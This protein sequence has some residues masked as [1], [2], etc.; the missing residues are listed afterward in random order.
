MELIYPFVLI[1][2]ILLLIILI[3]VNLKKPIAYESGKKVANTQYVKEIPYYQ[4]V[5]KKY[6]KL[7]YTIKTLCVISTVMSLVLI[8]RPASIDASENPQY[9]RDIILCM[10]VSDSVNELNEELV[11]NLKKVVK[12]LKGERFG[13]SIFNTS[14]VLLVPLTDD[15]DYV[16]ETLDN[17]QKNFA[18]RN[19]FL[20]T[21][22]I[23]GTDNIYYATE[24]IQAGTL[25][26]NEIRGSSIIGDGL[27]TAITNFG[28]LSEERTRIIIFSTDNEL[29]GK[30]LITLEEAGEMCKDRGITVFGIAP[31]TILG[32]DKIVMKNAVE[33][34]G[35][36]Y[37]TEGES[38]VANI[39]KNIEQKGKSLIKGK[40]ETKM[41]D[42]P[43]I[44]FVVLI[45]SVAGLFVLN[46]KVNL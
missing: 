23:S 34:T 2:G 36:T 38:N 24:Y 13:I 7:N 17:L 29:Y 12:S 16:I 32:S 1:I 3:F 31:S 41:T 43:E 20:K 30:E 40:K 10:D 25:V 45:I 11:E 9:S 18:L 28:D 22:T 26:G 44:P 15:Y 4:E 35:G 39:V 14:S 19:G 37:Y 6:K 46:K 33:I 8:A 5:M 42:K 27:A 21:G